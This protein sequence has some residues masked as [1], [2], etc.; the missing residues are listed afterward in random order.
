MDSRQHS[1]NV[2]MARF[3]DGSSNQCISFYMAIS[4][5][6]NKYQFLKLHRAAYKSA[7][8][9]SSNSNYSKVANLKRLK[10]RQRCNAI[11]VAFKT[12]TSNQGFSGGGAFSLCFE[13]NCDITPALFDRGGRVYQ[14][15]DAICRCTCADDASTA[16]AWAELRNKKEQKQE[17]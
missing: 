14:L 17:I 8:V 9:C 16:S 5:P 1:P 15:L 12:A 3:Q 10:I 6:G 4:S 7:P 11:S 13:C 2:G